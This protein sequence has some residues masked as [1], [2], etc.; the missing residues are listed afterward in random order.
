M[1]ASDFYSYCEEMVE[2]TEGSERRERCPL[3]RVDQVAH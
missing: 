2:K 3:L 1:S